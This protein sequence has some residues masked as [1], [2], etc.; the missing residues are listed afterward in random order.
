MTL[1]GADYSTGTL[2]GATARANGL[3]FV[4]RYVS[5]PGNAKNLTAAEISDFSANG[6]G[7][8]VV[9]ENDPLPPGTPKPLGG[10]AQGITDANS[11]DAQVIALGLT[12]C[13]IYFA[14]DFDVTT[15]QMPTVVAY[16]QGAASV[17]G[18][19]RMG[20]YGQYSVVNNALNNSM[21]T[22]SWQAKAWSSGKTDPRTNIYQYQQA[23][24]PI[25]IAGV[26]IDRDQ[27]VASDLN[28]GQ[29][30][31]VPAVAG[32]APASGP[33]TGGT[34]VTITGGGF[35]GATAVLFGSAPATGVTVNSYA[36]ITAVSPGGSGTANV[37][38]TNPVGQSAVSPAD[39]FTYPAPPVV[40]NVDPDNG[41]AAGGTTVTVTGSG[42]TGET[43]VRFGSAVANPVLLA[44]PTDTEILVE[45]PA[46]AGTVDVAVTAPGGTSAPS[47]GSQFSYDQTAGV[48]VVSSVAPNVGPL[49]G[50]TPVTITG[51]GLAGATAVRFGSGAATGTDVVSGTEITAVSPA[52]SGNVDVTVTTSA[53]VSAAGP[54]SQFSYLPV[55]AVTSIDPQSGPS[56]GGTTVTV[57]GTGFTDASAVRFGSASV[58]PQSL[59]ETT[60]T[61]VTAISPAGTGVVDV[62]VVTPG[63]TSAASDD[64]EFSYTRVPT[65]STIAPHSGP[66]T[67]R[68]P[69]TITGLG[70][71][72][73]TVVRFGAVAG[74]GM[75]VES[76]TEITVDSPPGAAGAVQV[77]VTTPGGTSAAAGSASQFSYL[78]VPVVTA[79]TP[80]DGPDNGDIPVTITGIGFIGATAVM[81]GPNAATEVI[82][83]SDTQ[84]S[85]VNPAGTGTVTVTVTTPGGTSAD[86][87]VPL[88]EPSGLSAPTGGDQFT[89][90]APPVVTGVSPDSGPAGGGTTVTITGSNLTGATAAGFGSASATAVRAESATQV[91]AVSPEGT[92][93]VDVTVT[94]PG[95]TSEPSD[96][97]QFTYI[98]VPV[99][100]EVDPDGGLAAGGTSVT[101]TGTGFTGATA[102][103]FG[104]APASD[105]SVDSETQ[106][107]V[108]SPAGSGTVNVTV[109]TPGGTSA[110]SADA[111][112][113]YLAVTAVAPESGPEAGGTVVTITGSGF[114]DATAVDFG[115]APGS[116]V[117]VVSGTEIT[118]TSPAGS[119]TVDVTVTTP[120]GTS[121]GAAQ[122]SY[123]PVPAVSTVDPSSGPAAGGTGVTITGTGFTGATAVRFGSEPATDVAVGSETEITATSPAGSGTVDVTV[124]TPG[125]TSA[126]DPGAQ[127]T[128]I[129]APVISTVDPDTGPAGGGT[130]VTITGSNLTGATAVGFGSVEAS[131]VA[132][133]SE[134]EIT[135]TSP[136]GSGTVDVT[137][138]TPGGTSAASP[139]GQFTY[140]PAPAISGV[141]PDGGPDA[142]G[143]DVTITGS[144][145]TGATAVHFGFR[146]ASDVAVVSESEITA[147]SPAGSGT[148]YVNV[149]T[150]G[151]TSPD[152]VDGKFTYYPVPAVTSLSSSVG[153]ESGEMYVYI[154]GSGFT[155]ATAV[156]FGPNE[157]TGLTVNSD[158]EITVV[159][160]AGTGTV[161]VTVTTPGGTS[162]DSDDTEYTYV[163]APEI[164]DVDPDSGPESG[165][166]TVTITGSNFLYPGSLAV[167]F[168]SNISTQ[169]EHT[170]DSESQITATSPASSVTGAGAV[171]VSN[172]GGDAS[173]DWTYTEDPY[174]DSPYDDGYDDSPYDDDPYDDDP[175]D[176]SGDVKP[177]TGHDG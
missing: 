167:W 138:T 161:D 100:T 79:V 140:I 24:P 26:S 41:P 171:I 111:E 174:D 91:T 141:S 129:P 152:I 62:S 71:A 45:S 137:V 148:A 2:P 128:Y 86:T 52:G 145:F 139:D 9:F 51:T 1:Q 107:T 20:V 18:L 142:G 132:V 23:P 149:T 98:P 11:A 169:A 168:R 7:I 157:A 81:F 21:A 162:A 43:A 40:T 39:V 3:S 36:Q 119:G 78:P 102:V 28:F 164:T 163:P 115:S 110:A 29:V 175:Y 127:F 125:G 151:G 101:I 67:G 54:G 77:A 42:F 123:L 44:I 126:A 25:I 31:L 96:D 97:G 59:T 112:F 136:A 61:R 66:L 89:Y 144:N 131:D 166:T 6:I 95:G 122:F 130:G 99:V 117:S 27:T 68:T 56:T 154:Y 60:D 143:T 87:S 108:A 120:V 13:P 85:A 72:D 173:A 58:A 176:D 116:D 33:A 156:M 106:I 64:D 135:A 47:S 134:S 16:L 133:G 63:G 158:T 114:A 8:V 165:G 53:G 160:P 121:A 84:I 75:S 69:V 73:A 22:Y 15:A 12:G 88:A 46:G 83:D 80:G 105:I 50:G 76:D 35:T 104:S 172:Y 147:T 93:T 49:T 19:Q 65:V 30:M 37:T 82:V 32:V 92:D 38:V 103:R 4:C 70:F 55:P 5:S 177:A 118:A 155:G 34:G 153:P 10:N 14:V 170:V 17:I 113:T 150:P 74:T 109:T 159:S 90:V 124:T 146:E 94:T 57:T 48:P